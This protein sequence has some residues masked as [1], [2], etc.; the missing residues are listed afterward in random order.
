MLETTSC[1]RAVRTIAFS[2]E[3]ATMSYLAKPETIRWKVAGVMMH[4]LPQMA[5]IS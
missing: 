1:L 2:G 3:M 5:L 4:Y